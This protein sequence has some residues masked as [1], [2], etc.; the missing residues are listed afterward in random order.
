MAEGPTGTDPAHV[1]VG[2]NK[3]FGVTV[4]LG[5]AEAEAKALVVVAKDER[6]A[7]LVAARLAG[8]ESSVETFRELSPEEVVEYGLDLSEHGSAK[9]LAVP[10]L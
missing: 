2:S 6:D 10:N 8:A 5:G 3:G 4:T 1:H 7:E 9:A